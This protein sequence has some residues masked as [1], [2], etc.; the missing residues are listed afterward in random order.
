MENEVLNIS[1]SEL[2]EIEDLSVRT[3]NV[4]E[5]NDLKTIQS[6]LDYFW[7]NNN[8]LKL[9]NCGPKSNLELIDICHKYEKIIYQPKKELILEKLISE[10]QINPI[11]EKIDSLT[12]RQKKI[13]NNLIETHLTELSVRSSNA[14]R[15]YF[16]SN[17]DIIG[18]KMILSSQETEIKNMRNVGERSI[19]EI[20]GYVALIIEFI[21]LISLFENEIEITVELFHA[22]LIRKFSINQTII[23]EIDNNYDYLN[24]IPIFRTI[25]VLVDNEIIFTQREKE[26]FTTGFAY[27]SDSIACSLDKLAEI[28][29]LTRERSRQVRVSIFEN[30]NETFSFLKG[31]EFDSINFYSLD[32]S[33]DYIAIDEEH[34]CVI[35]KNENT[36]FNSLFI[37]KILSILLFDKYILIGNEE[38]ILFNKNSRTSY[39]WNRVYLIL[40]IYA[41]YFDFEG[42]AYDISFRLSERIEEDYSLYFQAYLLDFQKDKSCVQIDSITSI[43]EYIL[44]NEFELSI[45]TDDCILF[46]RNT[47]VPIIDY[48]YETLEKMKEPLTIYELFNIIENK[49]PGVTKSSD[50]LRG[51]CQGDQNLFFIGRTST[52]GLKIWQD[53]LSIKGG[54]IRDIVEEYLQNQ[55]EPKHINEITNYV[56]RYRKTSSTNIYSNLKLDTSNRFV[57]FSRAY[58]GLSNQD[59]SSIQFI[60]D[61]GK[62]LKDKT[63][64]ESFRLLNEFTND[65]N[66]LPSSTLP[67]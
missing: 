14:L 27:F 49:Y 13:V 19:I 6:I 42:F 63:W 25:K 38:G 43:A 64:E 9:R 48:V 18:I 60:E 16:G 54:T 11:I 58:I 26:I 47:K 4:C 8:F 46:S 3:Q 37:N 57:F 21:E 59:Y 7:E 50:S 40:K 55:T 5:Y 24:G 28:S 53:E 12:I 51:S 29:E 52:Y 62:N 41:D 44:F 61:N 30:L 22:Y 23:N 36:N 10:N 35:N 66:R 56:N 2:S 20:N 45:N 31:L 32:F 1:L 33:G 17:I 15:A 39:N 34:T 67:N 65:N